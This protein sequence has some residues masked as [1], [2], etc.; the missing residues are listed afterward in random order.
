MREG[1]RVVIPL[2]RSGS[3][4]RRAYQRELRASGNG[5]GS[6]QRQDQQA[7]ERHDEGTGWDVAPQMLGPA[8]P[9]L[10]PG[11]QQQVSMRQSGWEQDELPGE[12]GIIMHAGQ[13]AA[14]SAP[15]GGRPRSVNGNGLQGS[16][17]GLRKRARLGAEAAPAASL[18]PVRLPAFNKQRLA[19]LD[20]VRGAE[21][22]GA[23][24]SWI[25]HSNAC[26]SSS[27]ECAQECG[28]CQARDDME[29]SYGW[30]SWLLCRR[31]WTLL[32]K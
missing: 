12:A 14:Q 18:A 28:S 7:A 13:Q 24:R 8:A 11:R 23:A 26:A 2:T 3:S 5:I 21:L 19:Q 29:E 10:P 15:A 32:C 9:G 31:S 27:V 16:A 20:Q 30:L 1:S 22:P 17:E 6:L 4:S 25:I